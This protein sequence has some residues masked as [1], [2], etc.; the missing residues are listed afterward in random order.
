M[1]ALINKDYLK[2][3][4]LHINSGWVDKTTCPNIFASNIASIIEPIFYLPL[5]DCL[6]DLS[7]DLFW[8]TA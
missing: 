5:S 4:K 7:A 6:R 2:V 3:A 1:I 8:Q